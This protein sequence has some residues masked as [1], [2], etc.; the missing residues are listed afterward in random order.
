MGADPDPEHRG[1]AQ[2]GEEAEGGVVA[3][4]VARPLNQWLG[5]RL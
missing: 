2:A 4:W 1:G 3:A 5:A